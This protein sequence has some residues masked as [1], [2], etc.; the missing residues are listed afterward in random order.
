M[1]FTRPLAFVA[2]NQPSSD[3]GEAE[4]LGLVI[5]ITSTGFVHQW[6]HP[7]ESPRRSSPRSNGVIYR[8]PALG[9]LPQQPVR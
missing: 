4:K 5:R 6:E 7:R 3:Q 9:P 8:S 1:G 2:A